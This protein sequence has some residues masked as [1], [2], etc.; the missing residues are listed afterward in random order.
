[1]KKRTLA[2]RLMASIIRTIFA[3]IIIAV[4][5]WCFKMAWH[6][7]EWCPNNNVGFI[8][9][10]TMYLDTIIAIFGGIYLISPIYIGTIGY[11]LIDEILE[12]VRVN[13]DDDEEVIRQ[14][15]RLLR[16]KYLW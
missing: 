9:V 13:N 7:Q 15:V 14:K 12:R 2:T 11:I 3:I 1:M 4:G 16:R 8:V 10:I 5:V 6:W